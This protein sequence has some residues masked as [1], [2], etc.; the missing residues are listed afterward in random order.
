MKTQAQI[1]ALSGRTAA[2][3]GEGGCTA[4]DPTGAWGEMP[5]G[6]AAPTREPDDPSLPFV[7]TEV[8]EGRRRIV[9]AA[10]AC[11]P[12]LPIPVTPCDA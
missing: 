10:V 9:P 11:Y 2:A 8:V 6:W 4:A 5:Q 12:L 1:E 3:A 7:L